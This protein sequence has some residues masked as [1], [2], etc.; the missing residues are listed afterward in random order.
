MASILRSHLVSVVEH[1][2]PKG[3]CGCLKPAP[4]ILQNG[5][6]NKFSTNALPIV[7]NFSTFKKVFEFHINL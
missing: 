5:I 2:D 7:E 6:K 1:V 3:L 4:F